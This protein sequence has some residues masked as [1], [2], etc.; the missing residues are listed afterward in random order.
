[1]LG[2]IGEISYD[3]HRYAA[4][5][6]MQQ[7]Q[8]TPENQTM[9]KLW[10]DNVR[11]VYENM[12]LR[13]QSMALAGSAIS[14]PRGWKDVAGDPS[15]RSGSASSLVSASADS[16]VST[17]AT[18]SISGSVDEDEHWYLGREAQVTGLLPY[19]MHG[20]VMMKNLPSCYS[21]DVLLNLL[22]AE[23]YAGSYDFVYLPI[24]FRRGLS[25][26][27][28]FINFRSASMADGF[29]LHFTGFSQWGLPSDKVCQ[30]VWSDTLN[31]LD[32]HIERYRNSPVMHESVPDEHKP[33]IFSGTERVHFPPPTKKIRAPRLW[34][35]ARKNDGE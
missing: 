10:H 19:N 1:L 24:D 18:P 28:A 13:H 4:L 14:K 34:H 15:V 8:W 27:Y 32:A 16:D 21:R 5:I 9:H 33:V 20:S 3:D 23:G 35:T 7:T 12:L 11:L 22:D 26:G 6:Q 2:D 17:A 30:V 25:L 29:R 31:G